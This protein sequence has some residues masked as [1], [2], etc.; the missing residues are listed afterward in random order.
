MGLASS[1]NARALQLGVV[2]DYL[3]QQLAESLAR[4]EA[5]LDELAQ[6][7]HSILASKNVAVFGERGV[8]A[9]HNFERNLVRK[10]KIVHRDS[11]DQVA[12]EIDFVGHN[13]NASKERVDDRLPVALVLH[14]EARNELS[15]QFAK[16]LVLQLAP[17]I[18]NANDHQ[19][20][21]VHL[22]NWLLDGSRGLLLLLSF[23]HYY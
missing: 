13:S 17:F 7:A 21:F 1:A 23:H 5:H 11:C 19:L 22:A 4:Y 3:Q 20:E 10:V 12:V 6:N 8:D 14:H 2:F 9:L 15:F 16:V 18:P